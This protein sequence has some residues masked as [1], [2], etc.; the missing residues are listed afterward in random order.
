MC[1][2][3][4]AQI[5]NNTEKYDP[6]TPKLVKG[7][8][9]QDSKLVEDVAD[10]WN[11]NLVQQEAQSNIDNPAEGVAKA[12][13][14]TGLGFLGAGIGN[15]LGGAEAYGAAVPGVSQGSQQAA[16]LAAQ[17]GEFGA[18]GLGKTMQAA[19]TAENLGLMGQTAGRVGGN[20]L[21][22]P[23]AK[24]YAIKQAQGLMSP[25]Q[26]Q[27]PPPPPPPPRQQEPMPMMYLTE[28]EKR[29]LMQ[30]GMYY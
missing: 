1:Y 6:I 2:E 30:Q 3:N 8:M 26:P 13:V 25:Q 9:K 21:S 19:S 22:N 14:A 11:W 20:L 24:Q 7:L 27:Q 17:T 16:Q 5:L 12:S 28:E 15:W 29:R 18:Y 10:K 23:V 4:L